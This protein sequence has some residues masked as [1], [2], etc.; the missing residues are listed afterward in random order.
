VASA[1]PC[2]ARSPRRSPASATPTGGHGTSQPPSTAPTAKRPTRC[3][4]WQLGPSAVA[5][6][7]QAA[8][9]FDRAAALSDDRETRAQLLFHTARNHWLGGHAEAAA[10]ALATARPLTEARLLRADIDRLRGR[11]EV[12]VGSAAVAQRIFVD[13]ARPLQPTT[14]ERALEM[15]VAAACCAS[16]TPRRDTTT[17]PPRSRCQHQPPATDRA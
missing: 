17:L 10:Q 7:A 15:A 12:N 3:V 5:G 9:A 2:I 16:T 13:A 1:G 14:P 6:T 8:A 11:L 4:A